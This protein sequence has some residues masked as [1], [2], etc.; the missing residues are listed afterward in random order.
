MFNKEVARE[1]SVNGAIVFGQ[2]CS[3]YESFSKKKMLRKRN[4][5]HYF[6]LTSETIEE[7][8]ALTYK[9]QSKA[10]KELEA[11]GYIET[12][13]MG[14]PRRKHFFIT[15]KIHE[16]FSS[17]KRSTCENEDKAEKADSEA[18]QS[19]KRSTLAI[20]KGKGLPVQKVNAYKDK[21]EIN[22]IKDIKETVNNEKVNR[23][24]LNHYLSNE[25]R[26]RGMPKELVIRV[27]N[28]VQGKK[29][30]WNY[31]KYLRSCLETTLKRHLNKIR[32]AGGD[33]PNNPYEEESMSAKFYDFIHRIE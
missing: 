26:T 18:L 7:E 31:E 21:K 20:P 14:S 10:I 25:Y 28:E 8:T 5:K 3:S 16:H 11:T 30:L 32:Y 1:V 29:D 9:Q 19:D 33:L 24:E 6:Y 15:N 4:G 2:L 23:E 17:D 13:L 12:V 27:I 22:T